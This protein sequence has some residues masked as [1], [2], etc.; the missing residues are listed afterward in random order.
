[1]RKK[2][3]KKRP[4]E[5]DPRFKDQLVTRFVNNLMWNGKKSVAFS[6]FYDAIEIVDQRK[7]DDEKSALEVWKEDLNEGKREA[8]YN[9]ALLYFFGKGVEQN[10]P[11]A[12]EYCKKAAY[13]GSARAMNNL[14][15][16][17]MR[18]LGTKKSYMSAYAWSE[19]AIESG[20]NSKKLRDDASMHLTPAMHYDVHKFINELKKEIKR[21]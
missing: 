19:I 6:I 4:L 15:Y 10:L 13:E 14:A 12:Y 8:M 11:L 3:A 21:D 5:P 1:M 16:M 17:Y 20:Y 2:Q 18:G 9:I 7:Q